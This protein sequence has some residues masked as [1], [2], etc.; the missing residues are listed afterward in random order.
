MSEHIA[1]GVDA[2]GSSTV[3][4]ASRGGAP[5]GSARGG[6]A[7]PSSCG[8]DEA[9]RTIAAAVR[10][11]LRG[12]DP[13]ALFVGAAGAGRANV[14]RALEE[15]LR[16]HL[17]QTQTLRVQDDTAIALRA[18]I[19]H[20]PGIVL[21][22]GTGSVAY[23]E[24]GEHRVRVGG[25]GYLLGDEGSAF[26]IGLA[27]VKLLA[28]VFEGRARADETTEFV[29][30]ALDVPHR[31]ALLAAMYDASPLD[32]ARIAALATGVVAL[33]GD[34]NRAATKIVQSAAQDL[35]DL[36][37]A[38]ARQAALAEES[39]VIA[40]AGGL[41]RENSLLTYIL[42]TR[43]QGDLAGATIVRT[44]VEPAQAAL[45]FAQALQPA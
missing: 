32:V 26:A 28:R 41:L 44:D 16:A 43:L 12:A 22:A 37:R 39:P 10:E 6:P 29:Q 15:C 45:R 2:G 7:N 30:H 33:A 21:I 9:A 3:V 35:A 19:P 4:L 13:D 17:P 40:F 11:S 8:V 20:G 23:A 25:S 1:V 42:Q 27:A 5:F 38:A 34:G 24:N 18:A 31:E 36:V 14:A